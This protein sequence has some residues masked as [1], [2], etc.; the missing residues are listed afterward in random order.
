MTVV[1]AVRDPQALT[2][3]ITSQLAAPP[4]RVWQLWRDPRQL[5]RWWG[6]PGYPATFVTH[7]FFP[8]GAARY[9]MTSPEGEKNS[10]WFRFVRVD[11]PAEIELDEGFGDEPGVVPPGTPAAARMLARLEAADGGTRMSI[12]TR[13][14]TVEAMEQVLAMGMEEGM[15]LALGQIDAILAGT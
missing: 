9:Y 2:L 11:E 13:F 12:T 1:D 4:E 7:E 3:T 5:E 6:P 14:A 8:G 15:T 10:G